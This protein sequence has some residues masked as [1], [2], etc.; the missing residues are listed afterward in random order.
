M[1]QREAAACRRSYAR[2]ASERG[3][4]LGRRE[5]QCA[6][7]LPDLGVGRRGDHAVAL[8]AEQSPVRCYAELLDVLPKDLHQLWRDGDA[9]DVV[10]ASVLEAAQLVGVAGV[11]PAA[12]DLGA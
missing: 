11:G 8:A 1:S 10:L 5:G 4:D 6:G 12:V 2:R 9:A 3:G 7:F